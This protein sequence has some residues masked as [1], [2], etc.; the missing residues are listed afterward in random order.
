MDE[1]EGKETEKKEEKKPE[2]VGLPPHVT[3]WILNFH[4]QESE[5]DSEE[6]KKE[7][8]QSSDKV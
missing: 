4:L 2:V 5:E 8:T 7:E 3:R 6:N 1:N